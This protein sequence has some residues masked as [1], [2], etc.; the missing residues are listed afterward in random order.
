MF[1]YK[2]FGGSIFVMCFVQE[3]RVCGVV[4]SSGVRFCLEFMFS[5]SL[6]PL[7]KD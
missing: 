5:F 1:S 2:G 6:S 7:M 4:W 3:K